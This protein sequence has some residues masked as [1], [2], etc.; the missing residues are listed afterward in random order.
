MSAVAISWLRDKFDSAPQRADLAWLELVERLSKP[1]I[2]KCTAITCGRNE[3]VHKNGPSWSPAT[4]GN[5]LARKKENVESLSLL[6]VD[7]DHLTDETLRTAEAMLRRYRRILHSSHSD[8][9]TDRCVRAVVALSRPVTRAEW[10]VFWPAAMTELGQPADPSCCD[11]NRLYYLPSRP[12]DADYYFASYEGEP[13]DVDAILDRAPRTA[14]SLVRQLTLDESGTVQPGERHAMLKSLA[15]AVRSRGAGLVEIAAALTA[16]NSARCIPPKSDSEI[17]DLASWAAAQPITTLRKVSSRDDDPGDLNDV[18][19]EVPPPGD[20]DAP[21]KIKKTKGRDAVQL[22]NR[23][24]EQHAT[25]VDGVT[26]RRWRGDWYQWLEPRG[27]YAQLTDEQVEADLYRRAGLG[28]RSEVGDVRHALIAVDDVLIDHV[29]LGDSLDADV[30]SPAVDRTAC[31]N[32]V[33]HLPTC[34]LTPAT[35]RYFATSSL[36]VAYDPAAPVPARW[37]AF[38]TQLWPD[39]E[40]SVQALQ[41]W[42]GYQLTPDTRQQKIA[43]LIGPKRS[44]KGTILRVVTELLGAA[45]VVSPT[46]ASLGSNF[47]LSPWIG[48]TA[49]IIGDARLGGRSDIAQIVERLLSISGEDGQTIDRKHRKQWTGRLTTRITIAVGIKIVVA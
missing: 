48:R 24:V 34:T 27:C 47:G 6:V 21:P 4:F 23:Y 12:F 16:A 18:G 9:S 15:G 44:G 3:C 40:E 7:L 10:P 37:L 41:E 5:G 20:D 26:L 30:Q 11:A 19:E 29:E 46:L 32:G 2:S 17:R 33:L 1:R 43:M 38:L 22:A 49:A 35:P 31:R 25:H 42:I 39:D 28:K 8:N 14:P 45:N 36:G 13:L